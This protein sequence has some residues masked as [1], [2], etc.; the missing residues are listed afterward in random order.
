MKD[1]IPELRHPIGT[2]TIRFLNG[3][4]TGYHGISKNF[5]QTLKSQVIGHSHYMNNAGKRMEP[6]RC[7]LC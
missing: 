2:L 5:P 3:R 4:K 7:P 1:V 6:I